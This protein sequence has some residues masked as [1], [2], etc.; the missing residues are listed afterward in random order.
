ML[1]VL[2]AADAYIPMLNTFVDIVCTEPRLVTR[3]PNFSWSAVLAAPRHLQLS[4][5]EGI[6][7]VTPEL[8]VSSFRG[9]LYQTCTAYACA[10]VDL[11]RLL[12]ARCPPSPPSPATSQPAS[13]V[14]NAPT[15]PPPLL[16]PS[17][18]A[19]TTNLLR[20]SSLLLH[21]SQNVLP[22]W[23][24]P[25]PTRPPELH[26]GGA[27]ALSNA[28]LA[29]AQHLAAVRTL[30]TRPNTSR[31]LLAKL[32]VKAADWHRAALAAL[33]ELPAAAAAEMDRAYEM[34]FSDAGVLPRGWAEGVLA[35]ELFDTE[36]RAGSAVAL[37]GTRF[38][39]R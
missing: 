9:E 39:L 15:I 35:A 29:Q 18:A 13:P 19:A 8:A 28:A 5:S 26:P 11:A 27:L 7:F 16:A 25:P 34:Y 12:V 3:T 30:L 6:G 4:L 31:K 10:L 33:R 22:A 36:G 1:R 38:R 23:P 17:L 24:D 20:A 37:V 32:F 2:K 14:P 21:L